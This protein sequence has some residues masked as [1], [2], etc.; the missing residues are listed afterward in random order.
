MSSGKLD[1]FKS[2]INSIPEEYEIIIVHDK[3]DQ[4]T[5]DELRTILNLSELKNLKFTEGVF[6]SPGAARNEGLKMATCEF[7][8]F[9]D[10]DDQGI[11]VDLKKSV[12]SVDWNKYSAA[13]TGFKIVR[14]ESDFTTVLP[15][16]NSNP[17]PEL[18]AAYPGIWRWIFKRSEITWAFTEHLM[19][20]DQ[21]FIIRNIS[22]ANIVAVRNVTYGYY[23]GNASQAT[24]TID[25]RKYSDL[26]E[27]FGFLIRQ[28]DP[29][30]EFSRQLLDGF[31][32]GVAISLFK[33]GNVSSR[34]RLILNSRI[35]FLFMLKILLVRRRINERNV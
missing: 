8:V 10:C 28:P 23:V 30:N 27:I 35:S 31:V 18:I 34:I 9:W 32:S 24:A 22:T 5:G 29:R 25:V 4:E 33:Y 1:N 16:I 15:S 2:S 26:L 3:R 11:G 14:S 21:L 13:V 19:G 12:E 17:D 6:G 7:I 20:E